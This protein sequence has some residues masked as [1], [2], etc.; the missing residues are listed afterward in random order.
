MILNSTDRQNGTA[1]S[2]GGAL[3]QIV[4]PITKQDNPNQIFPAGD[5]F[6]LFLY[7]NENDSG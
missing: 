5:R 3:Y 7:L 4:V 6:G 1:W 2:K